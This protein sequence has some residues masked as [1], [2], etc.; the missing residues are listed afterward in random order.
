[1]QSAIRRTRF[2]VLVAF[3]AVAVPLLAAGS[4]HAAMAGANPATTII[5]PDLRSAA[6]TSVNTTN[7][8][9]VIQVCFDKAIGS[10]PAAGGFHVGNYAEQTTVADAAARASNTSCAN[11]TFSSTFIDP[12]ERTYINVASGAVVN[13]A[14]GDPNLTDSTAIAGSNSHAGTRGHTI[15]PDL[16]VSLSTTA[17]RR[18]PTRW[19]SS[20]GA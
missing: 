15:A 1:M 2:R 14:T 3:A 10:T 11:V 17:R 20:S 18:S 16:R 12:Q 7:G 8:T 6:I 19:T 5:R 4:A 13:G 9:T